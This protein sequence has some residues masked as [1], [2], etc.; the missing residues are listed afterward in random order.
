[1]AFSSSLVITLL[2]LSLEEK[3]AVSKILGYAIDKEE[4]VKSVNDQ[5]REE[6]RQILDILNTDGG[7][8]L[9]QRGVRGPDPHSNASRVR[10]SIVDYLIANNGAD[11]SR[12]VFEHVMSTIPGTQ[13]AAVYNGAA[14]LQE[15]KILTKEN[16]Q[17]VLVSGMQNRQTA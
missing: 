11:Y 13:K 4:I 12:N 15:K 9:H 7:A 16:G 2:A 14:I 17:W 8:P 3:K 5:G 1:M 6:S 10:Q